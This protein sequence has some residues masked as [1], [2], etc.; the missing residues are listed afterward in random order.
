MVPPLPLWAGRNSPVEP[1]HFF[2]VPIQTN[3]IMWLHHLVVGADKSVL[4]TGGLAPAGHDKGAPHYDP[5]ARPTE[6]A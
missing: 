4:L 6:Y 5:L 2:D 3:M 1:E